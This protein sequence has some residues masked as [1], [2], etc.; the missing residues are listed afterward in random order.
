MHEANRQRLERW[1]REWQALPARPPLDETLERQR[2]CVWLGSEFAARRMLRHPE[3]FSELLALGLLGRARE[4]DEM[5]S[6]LTQALAGVNDE[7]ALARVLRRFRQRE[8][9]RIV[10][11]DLADLAPLHETLSEL[12]ELAELSVRFGLDHL[13]RWAVARDGTPR[14]AEG[15]AQQLVV[16]GMGKLGA[17]ELNLSSD[18]DLIFCFPR[19]GQTDSRRPLDNQIFFTRLA[20]RLIR[21]LNE[22][23]E[24][25]FVFRVDMRLRPFGEAGP[26]VIGFDAFEQYLQDQARPWERYAMVKA[27]PLTGEPA[28]REE[29]MALIHAFV[30]RRYIDF[31]V[32][33]SIRDMKRLIE[34]ELVHKGLEDNIKLGF[35][36]IRE[37]EFIGQAFQLVRGGREPA[38][39][40]RLIQ[41]ALERLGDLGLLP[42]WGVRQLLAAYAFL[43]RTENRLQAWRDEQTHVLPD[44]PDG[45]ERLAICM[46]FRRW[47]DFAAALETHRRQVHSHFEQVFEAPQVETAD[48]EAPLAR[49]WLGEGEADQRAAALREA[50]FEDVDTLLVALDAFREGSAVRVLSAGAR[51][52]LDRLMPLAIAA[53]G[54]SIRPD[55]ALRRLIRLLEAIVRR[56]AY[57][58]LLIENPMALSQ[59][60]RLLAES[61][62]IGSQLA[63]L[64]LLLDELLD[65][66][67]LYA[68]LRADELAVEL[69]TLL[70]PVVG[71][72]EQEMERLRQF[73]LG[74]RLRVAAADI[75]G[76]IPVMVVSDYL[77]EIAETV[78]RQT[79]ELAWRDL[80]ARHGRP[81]LPDPLDRGFLVVGYGKL[82]G[83][84]LGYGSDL[85]LVFVH[86]NASPSATTDGAREIANDLFYA[87]LGQRIIHILTTRTP[88]GILYEVDMRLR[89]NGDSGLLV[90]PLRAFERY[91]REDAWTWEHQAL[92][93]ARPVAGDPVM[94]EAF[95]QARR[96]VLCRERDPAVLGSDVREMRRKM[97][98]RL[99]RGDAEYFDIKQGRGGLVDIEFLV[100]YAVLRWAH[101]YPGLTEWT[102]NARLLARLGELGLL[103]A[104]Q[105]ER[106]F[107]IYRVY[108]SIVHRR[109][110]QE[111]PARVPATELCEERA[112]VREAWE[113][114]L[115]G[116]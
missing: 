69:A 76:I 52:R 90:S 62:W 73:A 4:L 97:S 116:E 96:E 70:R 28:D 1:E 92:V 61:R 18:I 68:P 21:L 75:A 64:P 58:D 15:R 57:L 111:A 63:R 94:A 31:G 98:A 79:L 84:E 103:D 37:I 110:L 108:R 72:L 53:A 33:E 114:V 54:R 91:Q 47:E 5:A 43:R 59:L 101:A 9:L 66:R 38:L 88:S 27:R 115:G 77:T 65:P 40:V 14:D 102:D 36:G 10:W 22:P 78:L 39:Q 32:I 3:E 2:A 85:D 55:A 24:E 80:D 42:A 60:V 113:T 56:T 20:R 45:R 46:G 71:D 81:R 29:L 95:A 51:T 48:E 44:D 26:L 19:Q 30:Y 50:G 112:L 74:N 105:A 67:S 82:G 93:R 17:R 6:E 86:G 109:A 106:L 11:R 25:G 12:S 87:R 23:T 41:Q 104:A 107:G 34:R 13:Y 83:I 99:D 100:Q 35:G 7:E 89:P 8:L 49:A 16:L